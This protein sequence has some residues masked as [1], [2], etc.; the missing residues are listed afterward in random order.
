[1][2]LKKKVLIEDLIFEIDTRIV[3][4]NVSF[5]GKNTPPWKKG[6]AMFQSCRAMQGKR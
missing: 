5:R 2:K 4:C 1:M 3:M 6:T